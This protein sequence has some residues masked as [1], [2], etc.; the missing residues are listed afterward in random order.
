MEFLGHSRTLFVY[1]VYMGS[2]QCPLRRCIYQR[3]TSERRLYAVIA[4]LWKTE[5]L[6]YLD[7]FIISVLGTLVIAS[8]FAEMASM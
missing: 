8:S 1:A 4:H 5:I 7:G 2:N 3:R 6:K